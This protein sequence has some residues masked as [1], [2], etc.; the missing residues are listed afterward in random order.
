[1]RQQFIKIKSLIIKIKSRTVFIRVHI[2][3]NQTKVITLA[4]HKGDRPG[5]NS[6]PIHVHVAK[7]KR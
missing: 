4:N 1:M 5:N 3:K 6:K 7:Q 2:Y